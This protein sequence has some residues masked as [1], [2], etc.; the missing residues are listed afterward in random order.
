MFAFKFFIKLWK[1]CLLQAFKRKWRKNNHTSLV[2]CKTVRG[3]K[4]RA[5]LSRMEEVTLKLR[6]THNIKMC[7]K[8]FPVIHHTIH[9]ETFWYPPP[10]VVTSSTSRIMPNTSVNYVLYLLNNRYQSFKLGK[11]TSKI[12]FIAENATIKGIF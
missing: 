2:F 8:S 4:Y 11:N 10:Q 3:L 9:M 7:S 5:K 12:I 1:Y 6:D